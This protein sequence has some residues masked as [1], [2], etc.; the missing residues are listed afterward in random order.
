M[1]EERTIDLPDTW[2]GTFGAG[3]FIVA[4][5]I[6][7]FEMV[8]GWGG[9]QLG[10]TRPAIY[11]VA[12]LTGAL[13]GALICQQHRLLGALC[14]AIC[15]AGSLSLVALHLLVLPATTGKMAALCSLLGCL[16]GVGL[17][18]GVARFLDRPQPVSEGRLNS[19]DREVRRL[20]NS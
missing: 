10:L 19:L 14:G 2:G 18:H 6:C 12:L 17:Y 16:P 13:S 15:G 20:R 11:S 5:L 1:A 9:L 7:S 3:I 4:T 8:P